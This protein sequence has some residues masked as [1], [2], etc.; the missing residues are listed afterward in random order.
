MAAL[1]AF[2]CPLQTQTPSVLNAFIHLM[3]PGS[4]SESASGRVLKPDEASV[5][6]K[7]S[8]KNSA[9]RNFLYTPMYFN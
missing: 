2:A 3:L 6:K 4:H 9:L 7:E 8:S 1:E 5:G